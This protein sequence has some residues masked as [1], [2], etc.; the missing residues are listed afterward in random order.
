[1]RHG[2][3]NHPVMSRPL[4]AVLSILVMGLGA[5]SSC[6]VQPDG[7]D[8]QQDLAQF[9]RSNYDKEEVLIPMRDGVRL[10]TSIYTPKDR[11]RSYPFLMR[12]TPYSVSPYGERSFPESLG[13]SDLLTRQGF[14]FV[15]QDV[16][17]TYMSEG[18]FRNMTPH[19]PGKS[20]PEDVDESSDTYDTIE[21]LLANVENHNGRVG[22]CGIS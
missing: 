16:R 5:G 7:S 13:P 19:N 22:Q 2:S 4:F 8:V 1:M 18:T 6:S 15:I 14:I 12:R 9:I 17:G 21:W 10:F 11:T 3:R 20:G